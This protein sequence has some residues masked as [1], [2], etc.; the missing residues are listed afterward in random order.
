MV[1]WVVMVM[2]AIVAVVGQTNRLNM[3]MAMGS[4]DQVRCKWACRAGTDDD[5]VEAFVEHAHDP[6]PLRSDSQ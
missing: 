6:C 1:L 2:T 3:K 4:L 5:C